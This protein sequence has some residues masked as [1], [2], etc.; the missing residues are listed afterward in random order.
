MSDDDKCDAQRWDDLSP[1]ELRLL[2]EKEQASIIHLKVTR[3]ELL[4]S[5]GKH[6][7]V[8]EDEIFAQLTATKRELYSAEQYIQKLEHALQQ[9]EQRDPQYL[10][11]RLDSLEHQTSNISYLVEVVDVLLKRTDKSVFER[12]ETIVTNTITH[13][14]KRFDTL[15]RIVNNIADRLERIELNQVVI[16]QRHVSDS[17]FI[18]KKRGVDQ[19]VCFECVARKR[20]K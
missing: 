16:T 12:Y 6:Q 20:G 7:P 10:S 15:T 18:H 19:S 14:D 1:A 9:A 3:D 13:V 4:E 2:I 11:K 17:G 8:N 5:L